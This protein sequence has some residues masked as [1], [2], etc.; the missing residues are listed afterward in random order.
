MPGADS[1][2]RGATFT[3]RVWGDPLI[4][5]EADVGVNA[6][7]FEPGARTYWHS[8]SGPQILY[9]THGEGWVQARGGDGGRLLPGDVVHVSAG[10]E[11]WHGAAPGSFLLHV[12]VSFGSHKW[13]EPVSDEEYAALFG[14]R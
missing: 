3:G 4:A 8:H 12:A 1:E 6:V 14:N 13:L 5:G 2:L 9:V 7:F 10:E 11:H